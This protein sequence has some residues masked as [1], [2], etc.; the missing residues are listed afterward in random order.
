MR[1]APSVGSHSSESRYN[2]TTCNRVGDELKTNNAHLWGSDSMDTKPSSAS[3]VLGQVLD[4]T[5]DANLSS[6]I[7][8]RASS[9]GKVEQSV[10]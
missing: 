10:P 4:S 3:T 1:V 9:M 5:L 2:S 8:T 6:N 7:P